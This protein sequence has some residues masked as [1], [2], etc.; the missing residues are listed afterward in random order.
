MN[1]KSKYYV[2]HDGQGCPTYSDP[3]G[4][5]QSARL[6]CSFSSLEIGLLKNALLHRGTRTSCNSIR[7]FTANINDRPHTTLFRKGAEQCRFCCQRNAT[8]LKRGWLLTCGMGSVKAVKGHHTVGI[9][10][11]SDSEEGNKS[12]SDD[13]PLQKICSAIRLECLAIFSPY[14]HA[15]SRPYFAIERTT[16]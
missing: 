10:G 4:L 13:Q 7:Q 6:W 16:F 11:S 1:Q 12:S 15:G 5:L 2:S 14:L 9:F 3:S 8:Q